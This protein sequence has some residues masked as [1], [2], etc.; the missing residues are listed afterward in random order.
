[1][2]D[3]Q[4]RT[5]IGELRNFRTRSAA[6]DELIAMGPGVVPALLEALDGDDVVG[7]RWT[8]VNC[9]GELGAA[10]AV[11]VIAGLLG[12]SDYQTVAHEAL[13][14][15]VGRDLGPVPKEWLRWAEEE[16][17]RT[18]GALEAPGADRAEAALTDEDLIAQAL[19]GTPARCQAEEP[20]RYAV[21]VP[22]AGG[23]PQPVAVVFRATDHEGAQIVIVYSDCGEAGPEHYE[24]VLRRNLRIP[25]GAVALR[26][27][28]GKPCFVMFNTILRHALSPIELRKSIFAI[29]ERANRFAR[30]FGD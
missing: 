27:I 24:T 11:P 26:D 3:E 17:A 20:D 22:L 29:A 13:A 10:Q 25:Y 18:G 7:A 28:D 6:A 23:R 15:I 14:K 12:Q 5:L 4:A 30:Q 16:A 2:T 21:D 8:I 1:M 9:L 19:E